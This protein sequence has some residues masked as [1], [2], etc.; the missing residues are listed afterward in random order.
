MS[1]NNETLSFDQVIRSINLGA[2]VVCAVIC[3][4]GTL[5]N[6]TSFVY[7][8]TKQEKS[9]GDKMLMLL[10]CVDLLLCIMASMITI[11]ISRLIQL[12]EDTLGLLVALVLLI[13]IYL[14]LVD[15]TAFA[16]CLL[17]VTRAISIISPF[18]KIR[19]K[20]LCCVGI[21]TFILMELAGVIVTIVGVI[22]GMEVI[23][24]F[25]SY[26]ITIIITTSLM[27][28]VVISV[29]VVAV[30]KLTRRGVKA[31]GDT[32]SKNSVK[33]SWTVVILA[34]LF[35]IFNSVYLG[36]RVFGLYFLTR[37]AVNGNISE[38]TGVR[39]I[40]AIFFS[41]FCVIPINSALNPIVYFLRRSDMSEF[42]KTGFQ[43]IFCCKK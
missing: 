38:D 24:V 16:T 5:T 20:C 35:I 4:L 27:I 2:P 15:G 10:N 37:S 36:I 11:L 43:K 17:S 40:L 34:I 41:I 30:Y 6:V 9:L 26:M 28:V 19:T 8:C 12:P 23:S 39:M 42:L 7:F 25:Y 21:T 32:A 3:L 31:A 22:S 18:Y 33:A 29:T 13:I 14:I 1:S